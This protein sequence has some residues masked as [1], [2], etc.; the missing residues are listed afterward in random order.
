MCFGK[1][2]MHFR[3]FSGPDSVNYT[4]FVAEGWQRIKG[5]KTLVNKTLKAKDVEIHP[6]KPDEF[7]SIIMILQ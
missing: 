7:V 4:D 1:E 5:N 3:Y 6:V 2:I